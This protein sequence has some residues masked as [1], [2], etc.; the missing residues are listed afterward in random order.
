MLASEA[1]RPLCGP[2]YRQIMREQRENEDR[3]GGEQHELGADGV[4]VRRR[5]R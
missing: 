3:L 5:P 1:N 4:D 2:H